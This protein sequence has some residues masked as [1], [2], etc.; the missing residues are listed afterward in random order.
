MSANET[1]DELFCSHRFGYQ[2]GLGSTMGGDEGFA[3]LHN[4]EMMMEKTS[5]VSSKRFLLKGA[6]LLLYVDRSGSQGLSS[7]TGRPKRR[8]RMHLAVTLVD[9]PHSVGFTQP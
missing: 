7:V 6:R 2:E 4:A 9:N 8:S 5:T 3:G 1:K